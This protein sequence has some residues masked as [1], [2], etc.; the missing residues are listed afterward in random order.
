MKTKSG[1]GFKIRIE[2]VPGQRITTTVDGKTTTMAL[3]EGDVVV[4]DDG[5]L[6]VS[7][8][9]SRMR[10]EVGLSPD[11]LPPLTAPTGGE[12][13]APAIPS[14]ARPQVHGR[15]GSAPP[16][17]FALEWSSEDLDIGFSVEEVIEPSEEP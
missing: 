2:I 13:A 11:P 6:D 1:K 17:A 16:G 8:L 10:R 7:G 5:K 15:S 9:L 3:E 14:E 4:A 12:A